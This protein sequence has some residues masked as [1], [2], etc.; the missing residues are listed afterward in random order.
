[1]VTQHRLLGILFAA[2]V[3][4]ASALAQVAAPPPDLNDKTLEEL[5]TID[6]A[7]VVGATRHEQRMPIEP[8]KRPL[9]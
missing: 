5:M 1:M 7:S 9:A 4:P 2:L 6:V 8:S 3:F